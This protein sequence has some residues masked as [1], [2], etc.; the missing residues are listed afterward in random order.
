MADEDE[1]EKERKG[2]V[3]GVSD[4]S[5]GLTLNIFEKRRNIKMLNLNSRTISHFTY[6][7]SVQT[8]V[9]ESIILRMWLMSLSN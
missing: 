9:Q 6:R 1:D 3:P 2:T 4:E 8:T 5:S 7:L